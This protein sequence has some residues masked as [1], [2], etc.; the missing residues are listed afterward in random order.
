MKLLKK[1]IK[2]IKK[3]SK[4]IKFNQKTDEKVSIFDSKVNLNGKSVY[5]FIIFLDF[6]CY[7]KREVYKK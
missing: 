2:K 6:L 1:N 4:K 3:N 7:K 5:F